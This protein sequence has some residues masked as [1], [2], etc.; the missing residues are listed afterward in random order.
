MT[1]MFYIL[2]WAVVNMA[3]NTKKKS[4]GCGVYFVNY[5]LINEKFKK[6]SGKH[7]WRKAHFVRMIMN[8]QRLNHEDN[9]KS[10]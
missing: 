2:I 1:K 9:L 4:S 8:R 10:K 5:T 6:L 7:T 3:Y